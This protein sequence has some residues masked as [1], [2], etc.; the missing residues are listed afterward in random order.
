MQILRCVI[1]IYIYI[2][3]YILNVSYLFIL[4][5]SLKTKHTL[6]KGL[7]CSP[8]LLRL[9]ISSGSS[10]RHLI[11]VRHL[12][13]PIG[14]LGQLKPRMRT[15]VNVGPHCCDHKG[16]LVHSFP[17]PM[18]PQPRVTGTRKASLRVAS[19]FKFRD[20][21]FHSWWLDPL[22]LFLLV[23]SSRVEQQCRS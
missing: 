13:Q 22:W 14:A 9:V 5:L 10:S 16:T 7:R 1:R 4:D 12:L 6:E 15:I 19:P 20:A 2:Y 23:A 3:I 11:S 8:G 21:R 17:L 18:D